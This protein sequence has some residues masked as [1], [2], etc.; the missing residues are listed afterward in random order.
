M[1][2]FFRRRAVCF[3]ETI[4]GVVVFVLVLLELNFV[5]VNIT[6]VLALHVVVVVAVL[7]RALIR[8]AFVLGA[9]LFFNVRLWLFA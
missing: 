7:V 6:T 8:F 3:A 9:E 2:V 4:L 5:V 1:I